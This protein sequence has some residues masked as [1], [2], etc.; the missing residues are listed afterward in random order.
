M[1]LWHLGH[2]LYL[3]YLTFLA[4]RPY[5]VFLAFQL[6]LPLVLQLVPWVPQAL[7]HPEVQ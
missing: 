7:S 6:Q 1:V 2:H 4:H 3:G 5:L